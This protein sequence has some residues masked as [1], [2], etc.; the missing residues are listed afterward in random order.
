MSHLKSGPGT[1]SVQQHLSV[2]AAVVKI[3]APLGGG[4]ELYYTEHVYPSD[5]S[6]QIVLNVGLHTIMTC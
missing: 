6:V 5:T 4:S 1:T 2:G 3:Q